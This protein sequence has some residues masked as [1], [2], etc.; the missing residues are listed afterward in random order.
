VI[1][2][3]VACA[4]PAARRHHRRADDEVTTVAS[5]PRECAT[6]TF[7][8][9]DG[10]PVDRTEDFALGATVV[11][12]RPGTL[13][14]CDGTW[15]AGLAVGADVRVVGLGADRTT[16]DGG[17]VGPVITV[18][19][20]ARLTLEAVTVTGG[21]GLDGGGI[22]AVDALGVTLRDV[23]L[24]GNHARHQGGGLFVEG[25]GPVELADVRFEDDDADSAGGGAFVRSAAE[26]V[27]DGGAWE[28]NRAVGD[29]GGARIHSTPATFDGTT[30][31]GNRSEDRGGALSVDSGAEVVARGVG[32]AGNS[33]A[34][35][36]GALWADDG[37]TLE[38]VDAAIDGNTAFEGGGLALRDGAVVIARG[39]SFGGNGAVRTGGA[40]LV[41]RLA[42][43]ELDGVELAGNTAFDGGAL[44]V[45]SAELVA[46]GSELVENVALGGG[47]AIVTTGPEASVTLSGG[48][49]D[50]N[51]AADGGALFVGEGVVR[52]LGGALLR[53][54]AASGG[55]ATVFGGSLVAE[56]CD[57]G[58]GATDNEPADVH[59][60]ASGADARY[61][62]AA[63]FTCDAAACR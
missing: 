53:N 58:A 60:F 8:P 50:A 9:D 28:G 5:E 49:I 18:E 2:A 46:T 22:A 36:G 14:L 17:G 7:H 44:G 23:V 38:L 20:G 37:A 41:E 35:R 27:V 47:G 15:P 51:T 30:F 10:A 56:G 4:E 62:A 63:V 21:E 12:S 31:E 29:G 19:P 59:L 25:G 6:A 16:L 32:L 57:L 45:V 42:R 52:C 40:A 13:S 33:A 26:L 54:V 1:L 55:A 11:L 24:R 39:G 34:E 48:R 61:G 3:L 43:L